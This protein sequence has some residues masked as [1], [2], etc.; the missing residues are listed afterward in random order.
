LLFLDRTAPQL[1]WNDGHGAIFRMAFNEENLVVLHN[2]EGEV[3]EFERLEDERSIVVRYS[4]G[5]F[6]EIPAL[7]SLEEILPVQTRSS[8]EVSV[9]PGRVNAARGGSY[10]LRVSGLGP[11]EVRIYYRLNGG[12][13][14]SFGARLKEDGAVSFDVRAGTPKGTYQ[15]VAVLPDGGSKGIRTDKTLVIE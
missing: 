11:V 15:F 12:P 2:S 7:E 10:T 9:T 1:P 8:P 3:L 4:G 14:Q 5:V 6:R 13:I